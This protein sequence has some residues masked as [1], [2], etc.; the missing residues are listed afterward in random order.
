[1][2]AEGIIQQSNNAFSSLVLLVRKKDG[3]WRFCV[4]FRALNTITIKD[5]FPIPSI[6]E[7]IDELHGTQWF[8]KLDLRSGYHT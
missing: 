1:M 7:L 5:R 3:L 6:E 8:S 2:M 4:D